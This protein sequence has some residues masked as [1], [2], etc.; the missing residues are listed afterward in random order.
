MHRRPRPQRPHVTR[1]D[2]VAQVRRL[3]TLASPRPAARPPPRR[4]AVQGARSPWRLGPARRP[5][6]WPPRGSAGF[7]SPHGTGSPS[8]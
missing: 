8:P 5:T 6:L 4:E 3:F 1:A 2:F 7:Q